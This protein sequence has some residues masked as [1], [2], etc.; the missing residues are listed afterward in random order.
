MNSLKCS[1]TQ[2]TCDHIDQM[3]WYAWKSLHR[4]ERISKEKP[5]KNILRYCLAGGFLQPGYKGSRE[6]LYQ[7]EIPN[8]CPNQKVNSIHLRLTEIP[9]HLSIID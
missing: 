2:P 8:K 7:S 1:I 4:Q 5:A 9:I 6:A 3:S